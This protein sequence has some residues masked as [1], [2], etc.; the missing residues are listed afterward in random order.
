M[1]QWRVSMEVSISNKEVYC[2][3]CQACK[4]GATPFHHT[5]SMFA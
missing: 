2:M 1:K 3:D 5:P 4:D